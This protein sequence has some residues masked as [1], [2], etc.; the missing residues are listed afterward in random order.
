MGTLLT[1]VNQVADVVAKKHPDVKVGT[2]AYWYTRKPPKT[3]KPRP[4]VQIQLCSIECCL[5]HP[6]NDPNCPKNVEFCQHMKDWG[7]IC[8]D[9][10]IWN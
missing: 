5:I 8:D 6:I 1:F 7:K 4:N 10:Y 3:I 2:L 9:I